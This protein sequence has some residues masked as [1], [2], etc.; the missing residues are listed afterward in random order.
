MLL[1]IWKQRSQSE[2]GTDKKGRDYVLLRQRKRERETDRHT[3]M[4]TYMERHRK[5]RD[6]QTHMHTEE[7]KG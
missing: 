4:Y 7:Q 5:D 2:V 3:N 1:C 6:T